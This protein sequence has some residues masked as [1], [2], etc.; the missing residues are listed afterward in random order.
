MH[1]ICYLN[2]SSGFH[3]QKCCG[4]HHS[5]EAEKQADIRRQA[6]V[7]FEVQS[8][9]ATSVFRKESHKAAGRLLW[10]VYLFRHSWS[11]HG[12][13][14]MQHDQTRQSS[15]DTLDKI[16]NTLVSLSSISGTFV[17]DFNNFVQQDLPSLFS[18]YEAQKLSCHP[19]FSN[20]WISKRFA[21]QCLMR[22]M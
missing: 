18:K 21:F 20:C 7:N 22:A 4:S 17:L 15:L 6:P 11:T 10:F 3:P 5:N 9:S 13:P 16:L 2:V 8:V 1:S 12:I 19:G 14:S